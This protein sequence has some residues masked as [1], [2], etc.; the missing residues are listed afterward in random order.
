MFST[1]AVITTVLY[2]VVLLLFIYLSACL[3]QMCFVLVRLKGHLDEILEH[4]YKVNIFLKF[5]LRKAKKKVK[6]GTKDVKSSEVMR[7]I[8]PWFKILGYSD[9]GVGVASI[10]LLIVSLVFQQLAYGE[11]VASMVVNTF[12][13]SKCTCYLKCTGEDSIDETNTYMEVLGPYAFRDLVDAMVLLPEC[14]EFLVNTQYTWDDTWAVAKKE[15]EMKAQNSKMTKADLDAELAKEESHYKNEFDTVITVYK[16]T[17]ILPGTITSQT[18]VTYDILGKSTSYNTAGNVILLEF[19]LAQSAS[20]REDIASTYKQNVIELDSYRNDKLDR[21]SMTTEELIEDIAALLTDCKV[22][23]V[24]TECAVCSRARHDNLKTVCNGVDRWTMPPYWVVLEDQTYKVGE[25][26]EPPATIVPG[27]N[28]AKTSQYGLCIDDVND[29]WVYWYHQVNTTKCASHTASCQWNPSFDPY[30]DYANAIIAPSYSSIQT[31]GNRGCSTYSTAMALSNLLGKEI[32]PWVLILDVLKTTP[33]IDSG[34]YVFPIDGYGITAGASVMSVDYKKLAESCINA[35]GSE[36]LNAKEINFTQAEVDEVLNKGGMVINSYKKNSGLIWYTGSSSGT[37][38]IT[39]RCKD[40]SG[41]YYPLDSNV[42]DASAVSRMTTGVEWSSLDGAKN[43]TTAIA[44][45]VEGATPGDTGG[46]VG[47]PPSTIS[48]SKITFPAIGEKLWYR[49]INNYS[50]TGYLPRVSGDTVTWEFAL[51]YISTTSN[52]KL[53]TM[54]SRANK[55]KPYATNANTHD[56]LKVNLGGTEYYVGCLPISGFGN[57][58]DIIQFNF[59]GGSSIKVLAIDAKSDSDAEG[60][61]SAGQCNT[62]F[63]H[64]VLKGSN[65]G[66]SLSAIELWCAGDITKNGNSASFPSGTVISAEI[67]G[68]WDG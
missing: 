22:N 12:R 38:Y 55:I 6:K 16:A 17:S 47:R 33:I 15:V 18:N 28:S 45:W 42:N 10:V 49:E 52:S 39:I 1:L 27:D 3:I 30:G 68:H 57:T 51:D 4:E 63:C 37:H 56:A 62:N 32:T 44:L 34:N 36:G 9:M 58:W 25:D 61:G 11:T 50:N 66:L 48:G 2:F 13:N 5:A 65:T 19:L 26:E 60:K 20:A 54:K 40:A 46:D 7:C 67:I 8:L 64:A 43:H 29:I 14:S 35:Y 41:L 59:E 23:G 21:S 24:N 53:S 31:G